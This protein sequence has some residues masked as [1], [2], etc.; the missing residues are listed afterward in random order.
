MWTN[1]LL[2]RSG[3]LIR[4]WEASQKLTPGCTLGLDAQYAIIEAN[5][6]AWKAG[7]L[8]PGH[9]ERFSNPVAEAVIEF[10]RLSQSTFTGASYAQLRQHEEAAWQHYE[11]KFKEQTGRV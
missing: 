10:H 8:A 1:V 3:F 7:I 6:S 2:T 5:D 9:A 4:L 11:E